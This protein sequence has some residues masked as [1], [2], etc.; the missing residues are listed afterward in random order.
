MQTIENLKILSQNNTQ[1]EVPDVLSLIQDFSDTWFSLDQFDKN[2]FPEKGTKEELQLS[3]KDLQLDLSQL[4]KDL[5]KKEK[6]L[7]FLRKK[8]PKVI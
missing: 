6:R 1:L 5:I 7:N 4:K 2:E 3:A 8:S